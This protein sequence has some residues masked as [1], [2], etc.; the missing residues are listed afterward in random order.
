MQ[1]LGRITGGAWSGALH[2]VTG[3]QR[4]QYDILAGELGDVLD[5]LSRAVDVDLKRIEDAAEAAGAPW[6]SGR[7]PTWRP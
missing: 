5:R 3:M 4:E 2:D 1:R 7:V 6:T